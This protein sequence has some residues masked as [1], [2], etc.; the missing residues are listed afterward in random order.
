M[1]LH[2]MTR[3]SQDTLDH[4][5]FFMAGLSPLSLGTF[6]LSPRGPPPQRGC[7]MPKHITTR[8]KPFAGKELIIHLILHYLCVVAEAPAA[9]L[10]WPLGKQKVGIILLTSFLSQGGQPPLG[11]PRPF[12]FAGSFVNIFLFGSDPFTLETHEVELPSGWLDPADPGV[13]PGPRNA[14]CPRYDAG[15][16]LKPIPSTL[17]RA[18]AKTMPPSRRIPSRYRDGQE[19]ARYE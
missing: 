4:R 8:H 13:M 10:S 18:L 1:H 3:H 19:Q 14:A 6:L 16:L 12:L 5:Q 9:T 2:G 17:E 7:S 15:T 11:L